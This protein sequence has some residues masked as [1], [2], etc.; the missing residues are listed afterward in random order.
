MKLKIFCLPFVIPYL[1]SQGLSRDLDNPENNIYAQKIKK[2][3]EETLE[4][5]GEEL[6]IQQKTLMDYNADRYNLQRY[7]S[8]CEITLEEKYLPAKTY[9]SI[10]VQGYVT[11]K[12]SQFIKKEIFDK[13]MEMMYSEH[14]PRFFSINQVIERFYET[15]NMDEGL[16]ASNTLRQYWKRKKDAKKMNQDLH[17]N[18]K[19]QICESFMALMYKEHIPRFNPIK[20]VVE[21]FYSQNVLDSTIISQET[22]CKYWRKHRKNDGIAIN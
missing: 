4:M 12:F 9:Y 6:A 7:H 20:N 5:D 11:I 17:I 14:I 8:S 19:K 15:Y 22:L 16:I 3:F 13:Y 2:L 1:E 10:L 18:K 21:K